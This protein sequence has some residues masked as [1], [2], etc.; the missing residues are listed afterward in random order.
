[1][2]TTIIAMS[3][4]GY[5]SRFLGMASALLGSS[6][7]LMWGLAFVVITAGIEFGHPAS[8]PLQLPVEPPLV[9]LALGGLGW[10]IARWSRQPVASPSIAGVITNAV[11]LVLAVLL[12]VIHAL[13]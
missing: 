2:R 3:P 4:L 13:T 12:L 6:L 8:A 5:V 11:P 9:G 10:L 7:A 1:M